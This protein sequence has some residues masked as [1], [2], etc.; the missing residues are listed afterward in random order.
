MWCL[1]NKIWLFCVCMHVSLCSFDVLYLWFKFYNNCLK[2]RPNVLILICLTSFLDLSFVLEINITLLWYLWI[3]VYSEL[4]SRIAFKLQ[5]LLALMQ[6]NL[7][8]KLETKTF[9][10]LKCFHAFQ[11]LSLDN[12]ATNPW[13]ATFIWTFFTAFY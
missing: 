9:L 6:I 11:I 3:Q 13:C 5:L 4:F 8:I 2:W 10:C 1:L 7:Y 12:L